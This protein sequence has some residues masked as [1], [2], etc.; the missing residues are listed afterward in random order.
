MAE[1]RYKRKWSNCNNTENNMPGSVDMKG[2]EQK[3][4]FLL[5]LGI[6]PPSN[7]CAL[8]INWKRK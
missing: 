4:F 5:L 8:K 2:V 1:A 7:L 6:W 3:Y